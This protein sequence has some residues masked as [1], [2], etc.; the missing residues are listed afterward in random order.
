[1]KSPKIVRYLQS[2][3]VFLT[4][5]TACRQNYCTVSSPVPR[6]TCNTRQEEPQ[7]ITNKG[8]DGS[9]NPQGG[10]N[11]PG[12]LVENSSNHGN[13]DDESKACN[14]SNLWG[15]RR[16]KKQELSVAW[17]PANIIMH[18]VSQYSTLSANLEDLFRCI[19]PPAFDVYS[20]SNWHEKG[21]ESNTWGRT[22]FSSHRYAIYLPPNLWSTI[23]CA[24]TNTVVRDLDRTSGSPGVGVNE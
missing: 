10:S 8:E 11:D 14:G 3:F 20:E 18:Q 4:W 2:W 16:Q 21:H 13:D 6:L 7:A 19:G 17:N 1:M 23:S 24:R 12:G 15:T 9:N 5:T 22:D